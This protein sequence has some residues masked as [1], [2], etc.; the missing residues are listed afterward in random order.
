MDFLDLHFY[1]QKCTYMHFI[2]IYS[3]RKENQ[4]FFS[5]KSK[6]YWCILS[7]YGVKFCKKMNNLHPL[8]KV[9]S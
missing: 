1:P 9:Y 5:M 7:V 2:R 4:V 8:L 6:T 3:R